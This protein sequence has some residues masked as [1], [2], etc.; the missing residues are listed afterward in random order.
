VLRAV[1]G[2][3]AYCTSKAALNR[4]TEA[5]AQDGVRVFDLSPGTVLTDMTAGMPMMRG[6]AFATI[7]RALEFIL[8]IA[9]GKLDALSGR[10]FHAQRDDLSEIVARANE[11]V[12]ADARQLRMAPY[13]PTDPV[14]LR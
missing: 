11:I 7:D 10:Y 5:L 8:A 1:P 14:I 6:G 3:S 2:Y 9:D 12:D 4:L 13:A